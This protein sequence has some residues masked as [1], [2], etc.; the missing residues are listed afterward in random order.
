[1]PMGDHL[2]LAQ[3]FYRLPDDGRHWLRHRQDHIIAVRAWLAEHYPSVSV[4]LGYVSWEHRKFGYLAQNWLVSD[5]N[6]AQMMMM[7]WAI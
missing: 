6:V 7:K 4:N 3:T 2:T 1:M 5:E